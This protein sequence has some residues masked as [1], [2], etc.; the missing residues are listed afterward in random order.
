MFAYIIF[1]FKKTSRDIGPVQRNIYV[2]QKHIEHNYVI[3]KAY[4]P[5]FENLLRRSRSSE[6]FVYNVT[7]HWLQ[8]PHTSKC[9]QFKMYEICAQMAEWQGYVIFSSCR[10]IYIHHYE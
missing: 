6:V 3:W 7:V 1:L 10:C 5:S 2:G 4:F 8:S 9:I